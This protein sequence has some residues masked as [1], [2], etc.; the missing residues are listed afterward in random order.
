MP[1]KRR[2]LFSKLFL[3]AIS[4]TLI[5]SV[6]VFISLMTFDA[7]DQR[8]KARDLQTLIL[9]TYYLRTEFYDSRDTAYVARFYQSISAF[10]KTLSNINTDYKEVIDGAKNDYKAAFSKFRDLIIKRG[11]NEDSGL[12]GDFRKNVH[13]IEDI[14]KETDNSNIY[15]DMLQA[16]RSEKD[17]IMR[18]DEKYIT[19]VENKVKNMVDK[20]GNLRIDKEKKNLIIQYAISY[21][22]SFREM[23][24]L[25]Y[26]ISD[27]KYKMESLE[28][29]FKEYLSDVA[30]E[31]EH[32]ANQMILTQFIVITLAVILSIIWSVFMAR[33][34]SRPVIRLKIA[35]RRI[36]EGDFGH[37]IRVTS[38]D[39]IGELEQS[40]NDLNNSVKSLIDEM[41]TLT[42]AAAEGKLN[43]RGEEEKFKGTFKEI[44]HE[45]NATLD[46]VISPLNTS[47]EYFHRISIGDLPPKISEDFK[48]E[49]NKIKENLNTCIES[50]NNLSED[51]RMLT[52]AGTEGRL[53]V[54]AD[55][56]KHRGDYRK[57]IEGLNNTLDAITGPINTTAKYFERISRG[58][59]SESVKEEFAGDFNSMKS[60]INIAINAIN[61]LI[62]DTQTI[63]GEARS[64][65]MKL[66]AD[67]SRHQGD[68]RKI[69][70][71]FNETLDA[72]INPLSEAG[73]ILE[74]MANGNFNAMMEGSYIGDFD[75]LKSDINSLSYALKETLLTLVEAINE[76]SV[77]AREISHNTEALARGSQEQITQVEDVAGA[78]EEMSKT[79]FE[80]A[81]SAQMTNRIAAQNRQVAMDGGEIVRSTIDKMREIARFVKESAT[82]VSKL[83]EASMEIG[84][85]ISVI[86]DIADQTNLLA[87]NAAIEAARAGEQGRGFA[88]VAD[89]VRKLAERTT[90]ATQQI[91]AM[92]KNIQSETENVV[93][94]MERGNIEVNKGIEL[95]DK[96]GNSLM[97]IKD[98]SQKVLE[99]VNMIAEASNEQSTTSEQI[100]KYVQ[101]INYVIQETARG[102]EDISNA[103]A[104]MDNLSE[105]LKR[106]T[107]KFNLETNGESSKGLPGR[108]S[109]NERLLEG[110]DF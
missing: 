27:A 7:L 35:A 4:V 19:K 89:E 67:S 105:N 52:L 26:D 44:I 39:E 90:E 107:E 48:G 28:N 98:S 36:S 25:F 60:N 54:R 72:I 31:K 62:T 73:R 8:D 84:E 85:I 14:I 21:F 24:K 9:E 71:G 43:V 99:H 83:G 100:A 16:R 87:L 110:P 12:E 42:G 82:N 11:L 47:A 65:N 78:V 49:F 45:F 69:I 81:N 33:K 101:S 97:E 5:M 66:R 46:N 103:T 10:G 104:R 53:S 94:I 2:S 3:F 86:D 32:F 106:L 50:I 96:A 15:V 58:D 34:I 61:M 38:N 13:D 30:T 88:V 76:L 91:A 51:A 59:I 37:E 56:S 41:K 108:N 63:L 20:A 57:I 6:A 55:A 75:K 40:Y 18:G 102:I 17:F 93:R 109:N 77:A 80:N 29:D 68:Y 23:A 64:G 95:A 1:Y 74:Q 92:I 70:D 79:I 22:E